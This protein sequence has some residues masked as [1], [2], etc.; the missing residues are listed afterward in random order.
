MDGSL[1]WWPPTTRVDRD[2]CGVYRYDG[3]RSIQDG[4]DMDGR[5]NSKSS[6]ESLN[7]SILGDTTT[8]AVPTTKDLD[9]TTTV[10]EIMMEQ[11]YVEVYEKLNQRIEWYLVFHPLIW[12]EFGMVWLRDYSVLE[13]GREI[14]CRFTRPGR[15]QQK[16]DQQQ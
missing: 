5:H 2:M 4:P 6:V 10:N 7:L 9:A 3:T 1:L 8:T 15:Q 14:V 12:I 16:S 13:R 11:G